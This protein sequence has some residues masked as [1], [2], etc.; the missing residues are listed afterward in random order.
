VQARSSTR[1]LIHDV[2][3]AV[4]DRPIDAVDQGAGSTAASAAANGRSSTP[5]LGAG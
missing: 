3:G 5:G 4:E 1:A 2:S